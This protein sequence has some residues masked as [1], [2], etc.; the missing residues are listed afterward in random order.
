MNSKLCINCTQL[1]AIAH[2]QGLNGNDKV[3]QTPEA[4]DVFEGLKKALQTT[5]NLGLPDLTRPFTQTLDD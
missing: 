2:G 4:S 1:A 5:P 3:E